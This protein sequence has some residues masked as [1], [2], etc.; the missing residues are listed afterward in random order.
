MLDLNNF[1][2]KNI[3]IVY[4]NVAQ[5]DV[6]VDDHVHDPEHGR[7]HVIHAQSLMDILRSLLVLE[8]QLKMSRTGQMGQIEY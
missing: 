7:V 6:C 4:F 5:T 2:S 3:T 8:L 1:P